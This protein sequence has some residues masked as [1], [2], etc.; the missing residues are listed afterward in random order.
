[1]TSSQLEIGGIVRLRAGGPEM[2]VIALRNNGSP[3]ALCA[4]FT[5]E[6]ECRERWFHAST[7]VPGGAK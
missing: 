2:T 6:H 5:V 7:L 3:F 1:V 4:W